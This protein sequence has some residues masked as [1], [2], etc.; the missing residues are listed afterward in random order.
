M[1]PLPRT[2]RSSL[3]LSL[4][5]S[6]DAHTQQ[7]TSVL[8]IQTRCDGVS[9]FSLSLFSVYNTHMSLC[10]CPYSYYSPSGD[11]LITSHTCIPSLCRPSY[12]EVLAAVWITLGVIVA[13]L[14]NQSSPSTTDSSNVYTSTKYAIG[15]ALLFTSVFIMGVMTHLQDLFKLW[16]PGKRV[17]DDM[18]WMV[19]SHISSLEHFPTHAH[20][21]THAYPLAALSL[22]TSVRAHCL[23]C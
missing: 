19:C 1:I 23:Q 4:Y 10:T 20:A 11:F 17:E 22:V 2:P 16:F 14:A 6:H 13:T 9:F 3:S 21:H 15:V 8:L 12:L 7:D 5:L 18:F